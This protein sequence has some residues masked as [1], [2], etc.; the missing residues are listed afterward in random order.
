MYVETYVSNF[1]ICLKQKHK[2]FYI[3]FTLLW[4]FFS[5]LPSRPKLLKQLV[6]FS[7]YVFKK[8]GYEHAFNSTLYQFSKCYIS[9]RLY[10]DSAPPSFIG[11][12]A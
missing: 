3:F 1:D 7:I 8:I 10:I 12:K 6:L 5:T 2:Y 9:P 4:A 11:L